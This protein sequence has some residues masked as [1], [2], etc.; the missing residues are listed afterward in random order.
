VASAEPDHTATLN[1][2]N[3]K[4]TWEGSGSGVSD[5]SGGLFRCT[6]APFNCDHI[7]LNVEAAGELT[8]TLDGDG[9]VDDP[10]GQVCGSL[11]G[12]KEDI[13][14][15][16]YRTNAAGEPA[17]ATVI[18][19]CASI[20][21]KESCT[22]TV[23]PG[24]YLVE[25]EYYDALDVQY[26]GTLVLDADAPIPSAEPRLIPLEGCRFTLYYFKDTAE[27]V[28]ALVPPGYRLRPAYGDF[29]GFIE[30]SATLAAAAYACDRI[31]VPGSSPA[32]GIFTVLSVLVEPPD[33][34]YNFQEP[35]QS[36]FYVLGIHANNSRLV[37]LLASRGMPA[38]L[39]PGMTFEK[40]LQSLAL[41]VEVPWSS[42]PYELATSGV[43]PGLFHTHDNSY[44]HDA[45]NARSCPG[46]G[47]NVHR[48]GCV[49]RMDFQTHTVRDQVCLFDSDDH[50]TGLE[51]GKLTAEEGTPVAGFFGGSDRNADLAW[52]HDP[53]ERS[54]L[55]LQ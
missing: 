18:T 30:G 49:V 1:R 55:V 16:L 26:V 44:W 45:G 20:S 43:G 46:D 6:D 14:G 13:D 5:P 11:W 50:H 21:S 51:C 54:W 24:L 22:G 29:A 12:C 25:V 31:E 19:G 53:I 41:R 39:V 28:Q 34:P 2:G 42:G 47:A 40:P 8:L 48:P 23:W 10:T 36:D 9:V 37:K 15:Y 7:L 32:P 52:D 35:P 33:Q 3:P 27:R 38:Y 4:F 17:G